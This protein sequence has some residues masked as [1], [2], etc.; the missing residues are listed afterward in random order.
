MFQ[1]IKRFFFFHQW[2]PVKVGITTLRKRCVVVGS[3]EIRVHSKHVVAG[4]IMTPE[5]KNAVQ[6]ISTLSLR[7]LRVLGITLLS[8]VILFVIV[9]LI[10]AQNG[11]NIQYT[12][13]TIKR[14]LIINEC[15]IRTNVSDSMI[16]SIKI[17]KYLK[18]YFKT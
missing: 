17:K 11:H 6:L 8:N 1:Y 15:L 9:A 7:S 10:R 12:V 4:K 16:K 14:R 5:R 13:I 18:T 3:S 2:S